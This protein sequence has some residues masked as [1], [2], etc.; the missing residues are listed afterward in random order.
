MAKSGQLSPPAFVPH[1]RN[2]HNY[3]VVVV[4]FVVSAVVSIGIVSIGA[5]AGA[6]AGAIVAVSA[7]TP[8]S[9]AFL[10]HAVATSARPSIAAALILRITFFL[11]KP[12]FG[13]IWQLQPI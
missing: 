10:A 8:S 6:G 2:D 1:N 13:A 3:M 12:W 7:G 5:G 4:I 11:P 9:S